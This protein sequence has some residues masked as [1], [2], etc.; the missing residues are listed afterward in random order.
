MGNRAMVHP[1]QRVKYHD[2]GCGPLYLSDHT[3]IPVDNKEFWEEL[4]AYFPFITY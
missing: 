1:S 2:E 4:R 3:G